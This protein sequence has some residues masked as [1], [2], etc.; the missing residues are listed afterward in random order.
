MITNFRGPPALHF[1]FIHR[2]PTLHGQAFAFRAV[3]IHEV[4]GPMEPADFCF[5]RARLRRAVT[6]QSGFDGVSPYQSRILDSNIMRQVADAVEGGDEAILA[7][8][9]DW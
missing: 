5:G 2:P 8:A 4:A 3:N 6:I 1:A 9:T 7:P